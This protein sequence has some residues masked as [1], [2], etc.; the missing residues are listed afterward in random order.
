ME[1]TTKDY[2][3]EIAS[4]RKGSLGSSDAKLL[5]QIASLG[6]VP[7]S[8]YKR[9]AV[10][11]G[12][13]PQEEIPKTDAIR[14]GDY[15]EQMIF[16][17]LKSQ[18][19]RYESNPLW[20]SNKHST[21]NCKLISHPD[22]VLKDEEKKVLHV[23]EVKTTKFSF[24]ETR[25]TYAAQ[26]YIHDI[27]AKERVRT[28]GSTWRVK[29]CLVH[30]HTEGLDLSQGIDFDPSR[31]TIK[32]VRMKCAAFDVDKAMK[33]VD[34]FLDT[35]T[36]YYEGDNVSADLLPEKVRNEMMSVAKM[37]S[38][39]KQREVKIEE[40]KHRLYD[41]MSE[42]NVQSI[43]NDYFSINLVAPSQSKTFDHKRYIEDFKQKHPIKSKKIIEQ[44]TKTTQ[45]KGY[46]VIKTF[47]ERNTETQK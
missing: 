27:L 40:F 47:D 25:R 17:Y 14:T 13:I 30:Y 29:L 36:E 20:V 43:K 5:A 34:G 46:C 39:I 15:I 11:K 44:Y 42:H 37:L 45:R 22:I 6:Y 35:F 21:F 1:E 33:I 4:T 26:L 23:Y 8:A 7:K 28:F 12:L 18:D 38:E 16:E 31:L 19:S 9:L 41:F 3:A 24:E 32:S 10:V 2:K